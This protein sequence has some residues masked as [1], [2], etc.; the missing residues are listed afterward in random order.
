MIH[1]LWSEEV[2]MIGFVELA[3]NLSNALA[4]ASQV[5]EERMHLLMDIF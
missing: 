3:G 2:K 5:V 4:L 1:N